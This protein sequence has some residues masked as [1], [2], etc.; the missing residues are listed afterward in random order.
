ME[1][2]PNNF[3]ETTWEQLPDFLEKLP[4]PVQLNIWGDPEASQAEAEA[5]NLARTLK[6]RFQ[7][8]DFIQLPRRINFHYYPVFG[9]MGIGEENAVDYGV[10][11]IGLPTG[12]QMTSLI[13]G[14]QCVSFRGMTSE[15]RSRIL[16]H[17]LEQEVS[18]EI[19]SS[20]EDEGGALMAQIAFNM[21]DASPKL[22]SYLI[23]GDQFSDALLRYSVSYLPHTVIDGRVHIDGVVAEKELLEQIAKAIE[24]PRQAAD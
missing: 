3:D 12:Y 9:V 21:A 16:L 4:E 18:V 7:N 15:A 8:I 5:F 22:R 19:I 10:R 14:I 20:A 24:P 1:N 11:I 2:I 6:E 23:M 13:A 17:K